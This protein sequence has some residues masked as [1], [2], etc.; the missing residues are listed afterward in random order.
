[1][2]LASLSKVKSEPISIKLSYNHQNRYVTGID[3]TGTP[4]TRQLRLAREVTMLHEGRRGNTPAKGPAAK[5][6]K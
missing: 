6:K 1:L 5:E 4:E 3:E 2:V